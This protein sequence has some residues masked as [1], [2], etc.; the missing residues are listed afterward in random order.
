MIVGVSGADR[1][2]VLQCVDVVLGD[3]RLRDRR[4]NTGHLLET[5]GIAALGENRDRTERRAGGALSL[6][7]AVSVLGSR[8]GCKQRQ[9]TFSGPGLSRASRTVDAL[10]GTGELLSVGGDVDLDHPLDVLVFGWPRETS[11][12]VGTALPSASTRR[13][14]PL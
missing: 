11:P 1:E 14:S 2:R 6:N 5:T 4:T 10:A 7:L 9:R 12:R 3:L 8:S 13:C